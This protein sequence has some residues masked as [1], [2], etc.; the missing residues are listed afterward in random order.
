MKSSISVLSE[1]YPI[2]ARMAQHK[3][4]AIKFIIIKLKKKNNR[5]I[6]IGVKPFD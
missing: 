1:V 2:K 6:S 5:I 3:K 4:S